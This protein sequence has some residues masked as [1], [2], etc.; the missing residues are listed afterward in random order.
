MR[1]LDELVV[2]YLEARFDDADDEQKA[3]FQ[4]LL[5]LSD[6]EL[7]SYL[8]GGQIPEQESLRGVVASI[9]SRNPK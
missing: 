3:A 6:P 8:L 2:W 1:E 5:E 9:R 4:A 7:M